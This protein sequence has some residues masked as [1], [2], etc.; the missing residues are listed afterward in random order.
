MRIPDSRNA[1]DFELGTGYY[2]GDIC[3]WDIASS[4]AVKI[5]H[6]HSNFINDMVCNDS[7][8]ITASSDRSMK[9]FNLKTYEKEHMWQVR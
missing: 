4:Q 6:A 9:M 1:S 7:L 5:I 3:L 2:L 8:L